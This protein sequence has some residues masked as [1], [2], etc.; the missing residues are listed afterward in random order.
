MD[1]EFPENMVQDSFWASSLD[2]IFKTLNESEDQPAVEMAAMRYCM[3]RC[4][5]ELIM[6]VKLPENFEDMTEEEAERFLDQVGDNLFRELTP[7]L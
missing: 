7:P 6:V 2:K 5:D 1:F 4:T 3:V